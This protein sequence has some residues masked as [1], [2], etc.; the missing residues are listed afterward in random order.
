MAIQNYY[1]IKSIGK[2]I[3]VLKSFSSENAELSLTQIANVLKMHISSTY[4]ILQ[5]LVAENMLIYDSDNQKYSL[6]STLF[7]LG[8]IYLQSADILKAIRPVMKKLNILT[9]EAVT[10]TVLEQDHVTV[11]AKEETRNIFK[12]SMSVGT[13][14]PAHLT[15]QGKVLLSAL[16]LEQLNEI[17]QNEQLTRWTDKSLSTKTELLRELDIIRETGVAFNFEENHPG[18]KGA[19]SGIRD[20]TGNIVA[21]IGIPVPA[22]KYND[23]D[24]NI[25]AELLVIAANTI[26]HKLGYKGA[27][28]A[29]TSVRGMEDWWKDNKGSITSEQN[30]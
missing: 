12:F 16:K 23:A 19:A 27:K 8:S 10:A 26:S 20:L 1:Y 6:G 5:T 15:A 25:F 4:R 30:T 24:I 14:E 11:I 13:I 28:N 9:G 17:Y 7:S 18:I 29:I 2:A 22:N 3:S 21:G